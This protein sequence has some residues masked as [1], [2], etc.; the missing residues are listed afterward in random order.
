MVGLINGFLKAIDITKAH[1]VGV[2]IGGQIALKLA[3][4]CPE[5]VDRL[6]V[7]GSAPFRDSLF[8][9]IPKETI[10][11]TQSYYRGSGPSLKKMR[12]LLESMVQNQTVITDEFVKMRF[13]VSN[14][15]KVVE[16]FT[17]H[18]PQAQELY[19]ELESIRAKTLIVWG[20]DDRAS[21][22][23]GALLL[24]RKLQDAQL[25]VFPKC[26][27]WVHIDRSGDFTD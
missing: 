1:F 19:S 11:M 12:D 20:Q 10:R 14:Q 15:P 23:D 25:H 27:H 7:V 16:L 9:P 2:S 4:D 22:L 21:G 6:V 17:K 8:L 26:G 13:E 18:R 24:L 5:R 3:I